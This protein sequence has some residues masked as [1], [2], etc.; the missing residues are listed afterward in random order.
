L[1]LRGRLDRGRAKNSAIIDIGCG[2]FERDVDVRLGISAWQLCALLQVIDE[3]TNDEIR[4][5]NESLMTKPECVTESVGFVSLG[6]LDFV[7]LSSFVIGHSS[8]IS[9]NRLR[10]SMQPPCSVKKL[11]VL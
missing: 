3:M 8:L 10:P 2:V 5:T 7:I 9:I 6:H 4:M 11:L 1:L